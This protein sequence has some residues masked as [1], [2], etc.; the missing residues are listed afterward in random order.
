M[1]NKDRKSRS[2]Q[3]FRLYI[4]DKY[5]ATDKNIKKKIKSL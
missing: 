4:E 5:N 1:R 3:I 2:F